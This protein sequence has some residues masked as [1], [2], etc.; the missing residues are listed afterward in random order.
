M[1]NYYG[2]WIVALFALNDA[3]AAAITV[4]TG[5]DDFGSNL[6]NCSLREAIESANNND[7]FGGCTSTGIYNDAITDVITLSSANYTLT[8]IGT[9][10]TNNSGD[11]DIDSRLT[12]NGVSAANTVIRGDTTDSP[13]DRHRLMHIFGDGIVVLN[14]LTLRDGLEDGSTA[15]GGL[16]TEQGT[17]TTLNRVTVTAN[18]AGGNAGGIRN[19]GIMTIN[20][21]L[22]SNNQTLDSLNGGGGIFNSFNA[23]LTLNNSRVLNNTVNTSSTGTAGGGGIYN[24]GATLILNNSVVDGNLADGRRVLNDKDAFGGGIYSIN[25]GSALDQVT[26]V[27]SS[28]TNNEAVGQ[29]VKGGGL[30]ADNSEDVLVDRTVI[31]FNQAT[32]V[33]VIEGGVLG[34]GIGIGFGDPFGNTESDTFIIQD[35]V[36]SGNQVSGGISNRGG[37]LSGQFRIF[38][39]TIANNSATEEGGGLFTRSSVVINSTFIGNEASEGAGIYFASSNANT[40]EVFSSTFVQNTAS[41]TGGGIKVGDGELTISNTVLAVN[42]A[43]NG[44]PQCAGDVLSGGFNLVQSTSGCGIP[45]QSGDKFNNS[46][47]GLAAAA[48]NGGLTAGSSLGIM[49]GMLTRAPLPDSPLIDNGNSLGCKDENDV[50]LATDQ[51]G[52]D[53]AIDGPDVDTAIDCDIGAIEFSVLLFKDGFE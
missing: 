3:H 13:S 26:L 41:D 8:R 35:S 49:A 28:I 34:G 42:T 5:T 43:T 27:Q 24:S 37:G 33:S 14:D 11:L 53:R 1:R 36:I 22:I 4:N 19:F 15:G 46:D 50:D 21:S 32:S 31:S 10:D 9:D 30:Y 47:G 29:T 44:G 18:T 17:S 40:A 52:R 20:D 45:L 2:F 16:R 51:I 38:R 6:G 39:S 25:D 48:N 23:T 7:D 12:I